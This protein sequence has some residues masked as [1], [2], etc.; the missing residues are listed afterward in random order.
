M[1]WGVR[2]QAPEG[3]VGSGGTAVNVISSNHDKFKDLL[4]KMESNGSITVRPNEGVNLDTPIGKDPPVREPQVAATQQ[5]QQQQQPAPQQQQQPAAQQ[6]QAA[7]ENESD[8]LDDS[9]IDTEPSG[10]SDTSGEAT[11]NFVPSKHSDDLVRLATS[12]GLS[13]AVVDRLDEEALRMTLSDLARRQS[14]DPRLREGQQQIPQPYP[15]QAQQSQVPQDQA[16]QA[17]QVDWRSELARM[18]QSGDYD[19]KD[20]KLFEAIGQRSDA[21]AEMAL[22]ANQLIQQ[23]QQ[24]AVQHQ[25]QLQQRDVQALNVMI[26]QLAQP[27]VYG[28]EPDFLS[29][30]PSQWTDAM[31]KQNANALALQQR[32]DWYRGSKGVPLT[33]E[34]VKQAHFELFGAVKAAEKKS[35]AQRVVNQSRSRMGSSNQPGRGNGGT[36]SGPP[37]QD[38]ELVELYNS[39][40][41]ANRGY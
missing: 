32:V 23:Q 5:Q 4:E 27:D 38:P 7:G 33:P 30:H 21:A 17:P 15:Q 10:E 24:F 2:Y 19:E 26:D 31:K 22:R 28:N 8:T 11:A 1:K 14:F 18:K 9:G 25:A 6:S 20:L 41:L 29:T 36:W 16:Q 34:L 40:Q 3:A 37:G 12:Y 39:R 13:K 35:A